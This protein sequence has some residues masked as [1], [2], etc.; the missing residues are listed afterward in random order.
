L[1]LRR[2]W[3]WKL[4]AIYMVILIVPL[5]IAWIIISLPPLYMWVFL[6]CIVVFWLL[7]RGY[8]DKVARKQEKEELRTNM[9]LCSIAFCFLFGK[10]IEKST[11]TIFRKD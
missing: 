4:V 11:E 6:I 5:A 3:F 10:T 7:F 2:R 9:R 8:R 1:I